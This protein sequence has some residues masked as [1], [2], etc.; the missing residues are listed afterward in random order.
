MTEK[1]L[2]RL[3]QIKKAQEALIQER[4]SLE[5]KEQALTEEFKSV[6]RASIYICDEIVP[7]LE[8]FIGLMEGKAYF[9][10]ER[11][12]PTTD[13]VNV[14]DR[15]IPND[16]N[17]YRIGFL[18]SD[19]DAALED[20]NIRIEDLY[21]T[22][23][24]E[25]ML[26]EILLQPALNYIQII[27]YKPVGGIK[28]VKNYNSDKEARE[29]PNEESNIVDERYEYIIDFINFLT[30]KKLEKNGE[31]LT[32]KEMMDLAFVYVQMVKSDEIKR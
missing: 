15:N 12:I 2:V 7:V 22:S 17:C 6:S 11:K 1:Q 24:K 13:L 20:I 8:Y 9:Y 32:Q 25:L 4:K 27:F 3:E 5:A 26:N 18:C 14:R 23:N 28:F 10:K 30:D 21:N 31:K 16:I 29:Y 19:P